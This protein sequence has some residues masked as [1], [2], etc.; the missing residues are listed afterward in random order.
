MNFD[1]SVNYW[2]VSSFHLK[3][4]DFASSDRVFLEVCE[5]QKVAPVEGW[6]HAATRKKHS[7]IQI[8]QWSRGKRFNSW[9]IQ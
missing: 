7:H 8:S 9:Q 3:N 5:E 4:H 2:N 1:Y 6:L